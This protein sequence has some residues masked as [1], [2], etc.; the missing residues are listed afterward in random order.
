LKSYIEDR[1]YDLA[2]FIIT[3]R[4]TVRTTA[5]RYG[6][7]KSTVH[8]DVTERLSEMNL[9]L[10]NKV[11]EVLGENLADRHF[12]GGNATRMKY[13]NNKKSGGIKYV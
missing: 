8:K 2:N 3:E 9:A 10:A 4:A 1:V 6:I 11:G 5:K 13:L 7:S 12:R